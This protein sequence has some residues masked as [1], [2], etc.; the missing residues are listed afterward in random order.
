MSTLDEEYANAPYE[1]TLAE[2]LEK[3][4]L[5]YKDYEVEWTCVVCKKIKKPSSTAMEGY[6]MLDTLLGYVWYQYEKVCASCHLSKRY[7]STV[8][9]IIAKMRPLPPLES[10]Y[11][12]FVQLRI[13]GKPASEDRDYHKHYFARDSATVYGVVA[14]SKERWEDGRIVFPFYRLSP[15][16]TKD[17][18]CSLNDYPGQ[19]TLEPVADKTPVRALLQA[20]Y[21]LEND[22]NNLLL[23]QLKAQCELQ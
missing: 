12:T 1:D 19:F 16:E 17:K 20:G 5:W 21:K 18:F 8:Y 22:V 14:S 9:P 13:R 10:F 3:E 15:R 2:R 7:M 23:D 11:G 6:F 4:L